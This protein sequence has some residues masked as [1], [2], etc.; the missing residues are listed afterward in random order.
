VA[1]A[2]VPYGGARRPLL[3]AAP[4]S[5]SLAGV[6]FLR[7]CGSSGWAFRRG[8]HDSF[9]SGLN[10]LASAHT[11]ILVPDAF[12]FRFPPPRLRRHL[13]C[14]SFNLQRHLFCL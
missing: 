2:A 7:V 3:V 10:Y 13:D 4:G 5:G 6:F 14:G 11:S 1:P 8:G 9:F 12:S